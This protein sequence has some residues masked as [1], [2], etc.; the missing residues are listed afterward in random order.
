MYDAADDPYT[1]EDSTVLINK[2][3]LRSQKKLNGF[4]AEITIRRASEPLPNGSLDFRHYCNIH[5]HLFQDVYTWAGEV[6][7]VR[8]SK[9]GNPFCFPEHIDAQAAKLFAD[10][11]AAN[12]LKSLSATEFSTEA[13]HFL[14]ELNAIHAFR[15]GNGRTQLSFLSL[16]A[17]RADHPLDLKRLKPKAMLAA[18]IASFEGDET[19]LRKRISELVVG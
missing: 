8:M 6:R 10:L 18:M 9:D 7:S 14:G 13:A 12:F 5:R 4:E 15:E 16:L 17:D 3:N 19:P 1:Y 11:K 2:L